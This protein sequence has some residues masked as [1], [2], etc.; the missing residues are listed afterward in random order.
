MLSSI[1][2]IIAVSKAFKT[3]KHSHCAESSTVQYSAEPDRTEPDRTCCYALPVL[4][5]SHA[6][7]IHAQSFGARDQ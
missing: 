5:E 6:F 1:T 4:R 3:T 2:L 7:Y